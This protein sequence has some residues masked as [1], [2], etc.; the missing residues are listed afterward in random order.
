L[1][2]A[3]RA[4]TVMTVVPP[5]S[6]TDAIDHAV[7]PAATPL[8]PRSVAQLTCVT[9][10]LSPALPLSASVGAV[11]VNEPVAVGAVIPIV[12]AVVSGADGTVNDVTGVQGPFPAA[13]DARTHQ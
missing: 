12:G 13:F 8:A 4:V 6:G 9:P 10:T 3:S 11:A 2:D 1:F 7:V 5:S